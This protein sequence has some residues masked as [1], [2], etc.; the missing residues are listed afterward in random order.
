MIFVILY[1]AFNAILGPMFA[2]LYSRKNRERL[3]EIYRVGTKWNFYLGIIPF[4]IFLLQ[5]PILLSVVYGSEYISG[6]LR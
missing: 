2:E 6:G 1:A 5:S 4:V 3:Q